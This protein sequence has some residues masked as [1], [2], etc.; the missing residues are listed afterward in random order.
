MGTKTKA[1]IV[2]L[3]VL[4]SSQQVSA[5]TATDLYRVFDKEYTIEYPDDVLKVLRN[6]SNAERY[7]YQYQYITSSTYD[8]EELNKKAKELKSECK[9][10][11][12]KLLNAYSLELSEIYELEDRLVT[13]EKQLDEINSSKKSSDITPDVPNSDELP[14][15][16]DYR[17]ALETKGIIDQRAELGTVKNVPYPVSS[18]CILKD[19][20]DTSVMLLTI[21]GAIVTPLWAGKVVSVDEDSVVVYHYNNIYTRY[22]GLSYISVEEGDKL[23]TQDTLGKSSHLLKLELRL[24]GELVDISKIFKEV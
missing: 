18:T 15:S 1:V 19:V 11:R 21:D 13:V 2:A 4:A 22:S 5:E 7:I 10:I 16:S 6:Y 12:S 9:S 20:D 3:C 23:G 14:T 24:D 8:E 17:V